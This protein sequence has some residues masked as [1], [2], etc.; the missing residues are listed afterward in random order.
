M[1]IASWD[2]DNLN[3]GRGTW[4]R[5]S[6]DRNSPRYCAITMSIIEA[7]KRIRADYKTFDVA[8]LKIVIKDTDVHLI[9]GSSE[10]LGFLADSREAINA[11]GD[12]I[13][14]A[15][16]IVISNVASQQHKEMAAEYLR[17]TFCGLEDFLDMGSHADKLPRSIC[18]LPLSVIEGDENS[19]LSG[20]ARLMDAS[21]DWFELFG[22]C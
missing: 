10:M 17:K 4:S 14:A 19:H 13:K 16:A 12:K 3:C 7:K 11:M 9:S 8:K 22:I 20:T 5:S 1:Q 2:V 21:G 15:T 18:G 6:S